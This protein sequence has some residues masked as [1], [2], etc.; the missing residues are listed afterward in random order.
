MLKYL[1]MKKLSSPIVLCVCVCVLHILAMKTEFRVDCHI[2]GN[3]L[4]KAMIKKT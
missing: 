4:P 3:L 2:T 1:C